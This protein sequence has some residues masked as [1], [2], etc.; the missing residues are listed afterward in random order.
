MKKGDHLVRIDRD[1]YGLRVAEARA[2]LA[3]ARNEGSGSQALIEAAKAGVVQAEAALAQVVLDLSRSRSLST[4]K[5][6]P[7]EQLD[8]LE[9]EKRVADARVAE[10]RQKLRSAEAALGLGRNGGGDA[11][12]A[13]R[14]AQLAQ[15]EPSLA[16]TGIVAPEDGYV[17]RRS[18]EVG[19]YV[20]PGQP[21]MSIVNLDDIRIIANYKEIQLAGV[22]AGQAVEFRVDMYPGRTF[23]GHVDSL[24]AGTGSAFALLSP[25]NASGN[26]VKVV[27][28]IS[29]K[30][31]IDRDATSTG[32][33]G[34][35]P[36]V[37]TSVAPTIM[38]DKRSGPRWGV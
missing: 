14:Q 1:D 5:A 11:R 35:M 27:Q 34:H 6:I 37:G 22:K 3:L 19:N 28:R 38:I 9:T 4:T 12:V 26:F 30:I 10:A 21:L 29:V 18:V 8:Q 2:I 36:K 17:T 23:H 20:Q 16:H 33:D 31:L 24:M 32:R 25:E 15:V 13:L 7:K